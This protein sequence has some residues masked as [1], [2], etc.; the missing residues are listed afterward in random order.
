MSSKRRTKYQKTATQM[1]TDDQEN[2]SGSSQKRSDQERKS[3]YRSLLN[4]AEE[5]GKCTIS[6]FLN[7]ITIKQFINR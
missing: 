2:S 4:K 1:D 3:A 5:I 7:L 6:L